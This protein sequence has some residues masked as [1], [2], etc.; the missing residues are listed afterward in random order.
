M[1]VPC[2]YYWAIVAYG[3]K[4]DHVNGLNI[5]GGASEIYILSIECFYSF[6]VLLFLL[7]CV[8]IRISKISELQEVNVLKQ[9][10]DIKVYFHCVPCGSRREYR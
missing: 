1:D 7:Y 10:V 3:N 8:N 4:P 5:H 6:D 9:T 2:K